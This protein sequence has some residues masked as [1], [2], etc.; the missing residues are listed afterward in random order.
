M[1]WYSKYFMTELEERIKFILKKQTFIKL[2]NLTFYISEIGVSTHIWTA[3]AH[4]F[5]FTPSLI[6][7][8]QR[9]Y[10]LIKTKTR[11]YS[12]LIENK[13]VFKMFS[14]LNI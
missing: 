7:L 3:I 13:L 6:L 9:Y 1:F 11:I 5:Y 8:N 10:H 4:P 2:S 12:V 14:S